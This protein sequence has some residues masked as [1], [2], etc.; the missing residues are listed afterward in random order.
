MFNEKCFGEEGSQY[1]D[2]LLKWYYDKKNH[3]YFFFRFRYYVY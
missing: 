1:V 3:F 2:C